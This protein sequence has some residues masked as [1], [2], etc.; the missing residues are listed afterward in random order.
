MPN[1]TVYIAPENEEAWNNLSNKSATVNSWLTT[2]N[3]PDIM[4]ANFVS[5]GNHGATRGTGSNINTAAPL[6]SSSKVEQRIVNPKVEGSTPSSPAKGTTLAQPAKPDIIPIVPAKAKYP[7]TK[8]SNP[9]DMKLCKIH[10]TPLTAN[11]KCLQKGCKYG[12]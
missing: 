3:V 5:L 4:A 6:E 10:G 1:K 9:P 7:H 8:L 12:K 2:G 11:G